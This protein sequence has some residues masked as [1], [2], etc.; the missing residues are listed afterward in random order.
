MTVVEKVDYLIKCLGLTERQFAKK[1]RIRKN[2]ISKWRQ[3]LAYPKRDNVQYLCEQ[4]EISVEDFLDDNSTLDI[5]SK[6]AD[7]HHIVGKYRK[8][9]PIGVNEDFP[10]EDNS[11]YEEKD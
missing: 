5:N 4:F 1:Y 6:Y 3:G 11:R 8:E 9:E 7:E 10:P 2:I